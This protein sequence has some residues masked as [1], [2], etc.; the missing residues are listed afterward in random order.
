MTKCILFGLIFPFGTVILVFM[1]L[2]DVESFS[3]CIK[4]RRLQLGLTQA[5]TAEMCNVGK[6]FFSELENGKL[7]LQLDKVLHC[8]KMLG[9]NLYALNREDDPEERR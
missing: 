3:K 6:R 8:A 7:T 2:Q 1:K 9:I 4:T 5:Q